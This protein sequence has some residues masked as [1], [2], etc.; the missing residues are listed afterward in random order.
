MNPLVLKLLGGVAIA[1]AVWAGVAYIKHTGY[2]EAE[3]RYKP[4][5]AALIAKIDASDKQAKET[6]AKQEADNEKLEAD[7]TARVQNIHE[8]YTNQTQADIAAMGAE[9]ARR[10]R[11][12]GEHQTGAGP[13]PIG[14]EG[15]DAPTGQPAFARCA[16]TVTGCPAVVEQA[17]ALDADRVNAWREWA[18]THGIPVK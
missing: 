1:A 5:I 9:Y 12:S 16:A 4:Q 8:F 10:L 15:H 13:A 14:V 7:H 18:E 6:K 17:C 3:D 11:L 2:Q